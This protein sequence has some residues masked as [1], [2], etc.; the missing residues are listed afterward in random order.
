MVEISV[1]VVSIRLGFVFLLDNF[2]NRELYII[3]V[4]E[5]D[6]LLEDSYYYFMY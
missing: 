6:I 4:K 3:N 5:L 2:I 1:F